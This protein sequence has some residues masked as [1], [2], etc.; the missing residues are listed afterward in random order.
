MQI[1]SAITSL[2]HV[3]LEH[4]KG[5]QDA[6]NDGKPLSWE[7]Q[8][9]QR[10]D[11]PASDHLSS[12]TTVLPQVPFLP[13]SKVDLTVQGTTLTHHFPSQLRLST[14][15]PTYR[16]YLCRHHQWDAAVF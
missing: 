8:L 10:C 3:A 16:E 1:L 7:A 12:A 5:H 15:L 14:G 9:N 6:T 4:V 2:G 11:E 13:G